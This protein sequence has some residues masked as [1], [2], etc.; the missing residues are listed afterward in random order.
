SG[1]FPHDA[2][3]RLRRTLAQSRAYPLGNFGDEVE[4]DVA[5]RF[6]RSE[7]FFAVA[8]QLAVDI[9]VVLA[10]A[11]RVAP[12]PLGRGRGMEELDGIIMDASLGVVDLLVELPRAQM[13]V[14]DEIG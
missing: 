3:S 5:G 8:E 2:K 12:R 7:P 4:P 11:H 13:A 9:G 10:Q 14:E 6:E 1:E